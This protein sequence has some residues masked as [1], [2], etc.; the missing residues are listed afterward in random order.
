MLLHPYRKTAWVRGE[1]EGAHDVRIGTMFDRTGGA[2]SLVLRIIEL[3]ANGRLPHHATA[4]EQ[5]LYVLGGGGL[6]QGPE[7]EF[8]VEEGDGLLIPAGEPH[9]VQ[10]GARGL[11]LLCSTPNL[12]ASLLPANGRPGR[13]GPQAAGD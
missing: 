12:G 13:R 4:V 8:A 10:A 9:C 1:D 2:T 6:V 11:R 5:A 3:G 7:G